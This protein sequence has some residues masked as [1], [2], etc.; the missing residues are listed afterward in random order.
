[1]PPFSIGLHSHLHSQHSEQ[2]HS[3]PTLATPRWPTANGSGCPRCDK[4]LGRTQHSS[5][6]LHLTFQYSNQ[7][8][9]DTFILR[10]HRHATLADA[11]KSNAVRLKIVPDCRK[12]GSHGKSELRE[13]GRQHISHTLSLPLQTTLISDCEF[14]LG[15]RVWE[16]V[17]RLVFGFNLVHYACRERT[18]EERSLIKLGNVF[19][20]RVHRCCASIVHQLPDLSLRM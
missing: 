5:F 7:L 10:F 16:G 13:A 9:F 14:W 19:H 6:N 20:T 8:R 18:G 12:P 15:K 1:M 4:Q 2:S 3:Q 11:K 17:C